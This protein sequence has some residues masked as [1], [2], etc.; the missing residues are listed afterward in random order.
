[1]MVE[2]SGLD[3]FVESDKRIYWLYMVSALMLAV[4]IFRNQPDILRKQFSKEVLWHP[5]ARLDYV[6]F[7]AVSA[8]KVLLIV[9]LLVG[10]DDVIV[11]MVVFLQEQFGY[12]E[13]IRI[14]SVWLVGSYTLLIFVANDLTRYWLHRWMHTVPLL[15]RFHRVHHSAQVLNPLTFYRVHPVENVLFG[16]RY[17]LTAGSVTALYIYF[18]GAGISM[19]Q[20]G[21]ANLFVFV[22]SLIGANLRHSHIPLRYPA[23]VERWIL[24]PYQHQLHHSV[25]YGFKNYGSALSVWDRWFGTLVAGKTRKL[26]F[27]LLDET[28]THSLL[29][30]FL[31][32]LNKGIKL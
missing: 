19:M 8:V 7:V 15:W 30:A 17:A 26:R 18:F 22:F 1:M 5:S 23:K 6:Y 12:V 29:G 2:L 10:A 20:M 32:P 13:R 27:G 24:S 14:A 11:W 31:N 16:L 9:P 25:H 4:V 21:G 3:F 28:P